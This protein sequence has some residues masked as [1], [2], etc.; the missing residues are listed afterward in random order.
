M[1]VPSP[2][3]VAGETGNCNTT[4][5]EANGEASRFIKNATVQL[6]QTRQIKSIILG[7]ND[8]PY[9]LQRP[10]LH[11]D[12]GGFRIMCILKAIHVEMIHINPEMMLIDRFSLRDYH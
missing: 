3:M 12:E 2:L 6:L 10:S 5:Y 8:Q 9:P 7:S 1:K 11:I 4:S